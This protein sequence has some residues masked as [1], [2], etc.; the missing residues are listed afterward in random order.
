MV[1][2]MIADVCKSDKNLNAAV[3]R[4]FN[5]TGAHESGFIGDN[6]LNP[7]NNLMPCVTQSM[8]NPAKK[9]YVYG[10][11]YEGTADGTAVRDY[12]HVMDLV[13]GHLAALEKL[14]R[15]AP[16]CVVYNLGNG[17][18]YTVLQV[19]NKMEEVTGKKILRTYTHRRPGDARRVVADPNKAATELSWTPTRGLPEMCESSWDFQEQNPRGYV[20][21]ETLLQKLLKKRTCQT[22]G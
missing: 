17:K 4:Y 22:I 3:L 14:K 16:G 10:T 13:A 1:E 15:D 2:Q 6:P 20:T 11:D 18:G 19:L 21:K 5:P 8:V 9:L 12:I 7:P